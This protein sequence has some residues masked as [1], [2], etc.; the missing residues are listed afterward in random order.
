[1][2]RFRSSN[3]SNIQTIF[4]EKSGV[5]TK[6]H[7]RRHKV[8]KTL[9][10]LLVVL[11]SGFSLSAF[12]Y[13]KFSALAGDELSLGSEYLGNGIVE[14]T[15]ENRSDVDLQFQEQVRLMRWNDTQEIPAHGDVVFENTDFS[16]GESGV[17]RLDLS[18]AYDIAALEVPLTD[19]H[20]Y[21]MLTNNNFLFYHDWM[22]A[23]DFAPVIVTPSVQV[24]PLAPTSGH[25][26]DRTNRTQ[27][28]ALF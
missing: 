13:A 24:Q 17:M 23:V 2:Q 14:I 7:T 28:A 21:F 16:A 20:Y 18:D 4:H 1:M 19:D 12:G 9:A 26:V 3:F 11:L 5:D 27:S 10:L 22:C 25:G 8:Q 15:V 6:P